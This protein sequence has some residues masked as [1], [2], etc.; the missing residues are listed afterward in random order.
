MTVTVAGS[1]FSGSLDGMTVSGVRNM[2]AEKELRAGEYAKWT[3]TFDVVLEAS[4]ATGT[5]A[6]FANGYSALAV[7]VA[8]KGR[9]KVTGVMS[10]GTRVSVPG[11]RLLLKEDA[12]EVCVPVLAPLYEGKLGG[13]G[14]LLW[15][16]ADGTVDVTALSQWDATASESAPFSATLNHVSSSPMAVPGD[17]TLSFAVD[18]DGVPLDMGTGFDYFGKLAWHGAKGI[19]PEQ[20]ANRALLRTV[21]AK[22]GFR[23]FEKEWWH[24][25]LSPEPFSSGFDFPVK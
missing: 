25:R 2:S 3:G 14:F 16:S 23:H 10:D 15:I 6:A 8:A 7:A 17:G 22:Y 12:S 19:T 9:A 1:S 13:F 21:M 18:A 4:N 5:G 11:L 20:T 24:Y